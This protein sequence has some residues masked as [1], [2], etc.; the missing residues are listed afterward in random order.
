[1][2]ICNYDLLPFNN[3]GSNVYSQNGEDGIISEILNQLN[4]KG[5]GNFWCVEFGAWDGI[6][7]SNT[8]KLVENDNWNAVYIEGDE[9]RF[10]DLLKTASKHKKIIP[11][12][13]YVSRY[14]NDS[15]SLDNLLAKTSIPEDFDILSIDIDTYDCDIWES[16]VK[17]S[18]KIV[19]IEINSSIPPGIIWRHG[20]KTPGNTFTATLNVGISKGYTLICHTGN[21]IFVK[22][23]LI[24]RIKISKKFLENPNL[25]FIDSWI[26]ECYSKKS[27]LLINKFLSYTRKFFKN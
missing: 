27:E 1:M 12:H 9:N 23:E 7:L 15:Y 8:F 20:K 2:N 21:L 4:I 25:L 26:P 17:Y 5:N 14:G 16:L 18:A 19:I 6:H 22:N 13:A 3:Y 10:N 11:V 24:P